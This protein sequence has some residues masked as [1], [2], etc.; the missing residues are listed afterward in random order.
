M[1]KAVDTCMIMLANCS[2]RYKDVNSFFIAYWCQ[3]MNNVTAICL[4]TTQS[5]GY[6]ECSILAFYTSPVQLCPDTYVHTA[7][8]NAQTYSTKLVASR[9]H[10]YNIS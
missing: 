4:Q 7:A 10:D 8:P 5:A 1:Y 2:V 9:N 3:E 6:C